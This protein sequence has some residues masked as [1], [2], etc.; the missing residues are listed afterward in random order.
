MVFHPV[1]FFMLFECVWKG[2]IAVKPKLTMNLFTRAN[3]FQ[4]LE[5]ISIVTCFGIFVSQAL[6]F[7][8]LYLQEAIISG[9]QIV[10]NGILNHPSVTVC[11]YTIHK[12]TEYPMTMEEFMKY[13]YKWVWVSWKIFQFYWSICNLEESVQ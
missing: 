8:N 9:S 6:V 10:R 12:S 3:L 13:S 2:K 7:F 1:S 11:P 4:L 5:Y